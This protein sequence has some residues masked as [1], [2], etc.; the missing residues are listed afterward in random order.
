MA[1][2]FTPQIKDHVKQT[3]LA[4]LQFRRA[5]KA[6][7]KTKSID[8]ADFQFILQAAR[9]APSSNGLEPWNIIVLDE[10][11]LRAE[12]VSRTGARPEQALDAAK[13]VAFTCKT[14]KGIDPDGDYL[15]H[16]GTAVHGMDAAAVAAWR[17]RFRGFLETRIR[18]WGSADAMYG[19]TARQAYLALE[20]ALTAA[21]AIQVDTCALEGLDYSQADQVLAEAGLINLELDRFAV[22]AVFGY[23]AEDPKRPQERR[24]FDEVVRFA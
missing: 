15:A 14:A 9:L 21:A 7:D 18:V 4:T 11:K 8:P 6:F 1:D 20:N 16:I 2:A 22:G 13:L 12:F 5:I 17:Q 23:R 24:C 3:H 10:P 19:Y